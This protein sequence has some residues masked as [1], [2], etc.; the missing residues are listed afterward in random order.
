MGRMMLLLILVFSFFISRATHI[1]GGE[2]F[3]TYLGND[4]YSVTLKVF[5][6][7]GPTNTLGTGFD[8]E[9]KVAVY[10]N[11]NSSIEYTVMSMPLGSA[12]INFVPVVLENPCFVLPPD[13]CVQQ[14]IYTQTIILPPN[15]GG[16]TLTHQRCCRNPSIV[17]LIVPQ[18]QGATFTTTIPGTNILPV[19]TNSCARFTQLPPV[20]L[21]QNAQF[22]FNHSAIDPDNDSLAYHL[23]SP[24]LGG[25]QDNPA[26]NPPTGPPYA[27]VAWGATFNAS[28]PITSNPAFTID[29][30]TGHMSGTATQVGQFVIGVCV[31][32][33]RSG[34]LINTTNRDF[35]FNVTI[36]D[37]SILASGPPD[38]EFCLGETIEFVNNSVN[39]TFYHWD[40]GV[41]G[42]ESDTSNLETPSFTYVSSGIYNVRLI[43]NPGWPCADTAYSQV[44]SLSI[45]NPE[46]IMEGYSCINNGDYYSFT[47]EATVGDNAVYSWDFGAGSIPQFSSLASPGN[48]KMNDEASAMSVSLFVTEVGGCPESDE[49]HI[50]NPPN[51]FASIVPQDIFCEGYFY[52]FESLPTQAQNYKWDFGIPGDSDVTTLQNPGFLFPD[53]GQYVVTLVVNA[54]FTCPDTTSRVFK[55]YQLLA[56]FFLE[57]DPMCLDVNSFDF[58]GSGSTTGSAVYSWDFG[59]FANTQF[60]HTQNPQNII[61][62]QAGHHEVRLT[63]SEN[64]CERTFTDDVW[65]PDNMIADFEIVNA[66]GCPSLEVTFNALVQADSP[67]SYFWDLGDGTT[68]A[69]A[70]VTHTYKNS[71]YYDVSVTVAT[72]SGCIETKT[73]LFR[74]N[75]FV[76]PVPTAR[77]VIDPQQINI[78]EPHIVVRDSSIGATECYYTLSDGSLYNEFDFKHSWNEAG[79]QWI[80]QHVTNEYGCRDDI[81][82]EVAISGH[83]FYAPNSFTPNDDGVNEVWFPV[84]SGIKDYHILIFDRWGEVVFESYDYEQSWKGDFQDGEY[85]VPNGVYQYLIR[86]SDLLSYPIEY[87]GHIILTR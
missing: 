58:N 43:A 3:Y 56:P 61:F 71:G 25:N 67:L 80:T 48:I 84:M 4:Q 75:V 42:V 5:R 68:H 76:Y 35:Q 22:T 59:S 19:G 17:N 33:Y 66:Q 13:V 12:T 10:A 44:T 32:E 57:Q 11:P 72:T 70:S 53:T 87:N 36:C 73:K 24:M 38:F 6:D 20:A 51:V 31:S 81:T 77:F 79:K 74:Q 52:Q 30:V 83:Y 7:C 69:A 26:P 39:A 49:I 2:I 9:A 63:V 64:G 55:I 18:S 16:Y 62:S 27:P 78:L 21:C 86:F 23:C 40:F 41:E 45:I 82:G 28:D 85:F 29:P 60:S 34:V 15:A 14:A 37:P 50:V 8:A 1:V 54:P 47:S 46:I 65:V